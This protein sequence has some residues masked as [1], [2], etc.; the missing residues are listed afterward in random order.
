MLWLPC[1]LLV[2]IP[3]G[4]AAPAAPVGPAVQSGADTITPTGMTT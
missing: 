2:V 4:P 3:A 1:L